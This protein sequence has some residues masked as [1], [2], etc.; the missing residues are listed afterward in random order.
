MPKKLPEREQSPFGQRLA[1]A[2]RWAGKTQMEVCKH[3]GISQG[4]YSELEKDANNS[5]FTVE[6]IHGTWGIFGE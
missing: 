3:C 4:S 2:R 1:N 5:R 6:C